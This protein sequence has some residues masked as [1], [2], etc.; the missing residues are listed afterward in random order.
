MRVGNFSDGNFSDVAYALN[1]AQN[2]AGYHVRFA[3]ASPPKPQRARGPRPPTAQTR[4]SVRRY[5]VSRFIIYPPSVLR[6]PG[7]T[8]PSPGQCARGLRPPIAQPRVRLAVIVCLGILFS[9]LP[10]RRAGGTWQRTTL[11]TRRVGQRN[12]KLTIPRRPS[13]GPSAAPPRPWCWQCAACTTPL[14]TRT[15]NSCP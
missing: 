12:N 6:S 11:R 3:S 14:R 10:P 9:P 2:K 4:V 15:S 7:S 5:R 1:G 13:P 8:H